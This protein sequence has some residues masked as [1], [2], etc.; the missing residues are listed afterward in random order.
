MIAGGNVLRAEYYMARVQQQGRRWCQQYFDCIGDVIDRRHD[1]NEW[2][3][4]SN[5]RQ[6]DA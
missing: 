4:S 3:G 2:M 5:Y 6:P 1:G